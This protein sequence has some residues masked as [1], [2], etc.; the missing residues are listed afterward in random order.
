MSKELVFSHA[1]RAAFE[2]MSNPQLKGGGVNTFYVQ[3]EKITI[4]AVLIQEKQLTT[5]TNILRFN[6]GTDKAAPTA[7]LNNVN[8]GDNDIAMIYAVQFLIGEGANVNTRV[9]RSYGPSAQDNVIYKGQMSF[10]MEQNTLVDKVDMM[11]FRKEAGSFQDQYD[12]SAIINPMRIVTGRI[13]KFDVI[14]TLPEISALVFTPNL[15]VSCRL[16]VALGQ[17]TAVK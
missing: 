13:S 14:V 4:P 6:F 12:G 11:N 15:F 1:Q 3:P 2:T 10:Q 7:A 8:L 5:N 17:A 9:Y 16:H